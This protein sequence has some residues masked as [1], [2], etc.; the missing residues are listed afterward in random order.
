MVGVTAFPLFV[1]ML[2]A[3]G[4]ALDRAIARLLHSDD[5]GDSCDVDRRIEESAAE[6]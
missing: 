5:L 2:A 4:S 6:I 3:G 1:I